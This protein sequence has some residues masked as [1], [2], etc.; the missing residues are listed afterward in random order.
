[1]TPAQLKKLDQQLT[2]FLD[3][4][5][6]DMGRPER[7]RA[8]ALYLTGLLLSGER[9][10]A[11][12]MGRRLASCD[13]EFEGMRQKLQQC[14]SISRWADEE[15]RRRL[16]LRFEKK[17]Q[18]EAFIIDDTGFPKK[19]KHSVG[20]KRQYSG[21]LGRRDSCQVAPSLHVASN[22]SSGCIGMRLYLPE[23]W[24]SDIPRRRSVGVPEDVVFQRKW[25]IAVDL[26]DDALS[27]G[28]PKRLVI[29]DAGF[30]EGTG[31]RDALVERGCPYLVGIPSTHTM[32]PPGSNPR[33]P[34]RQSPVGRPR[35]RY[36]DGKRKPIPISEVGEQLRFRKFTVPNGRGGTKSGHFAFERIQLA[37]R[38]AKGRPPSDKLWLICEWRPGKKE[39][40]YHVSNLPGSTTKS[41]LVRLVK[42]RWRVERD[43]Q[44]MKS[45]IGLDHYE[46]RTWR[47]F[48]HH[49]TLCAVAHGFLAIQRR[50]SPPEGIPV[51]A[52]HGATTAP[53]VAARTNRRVPTVSPTV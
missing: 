28:L 20:V 2:E 24:A 13:E 34:E 44:E 39:Y 10:T 4:I 1:M 43:Y 35:T 37:E 19:G 18:P 16:A 3:Y 29:A 17:L 30:G 14:V 5:T 12:S 31:F 21:T 47:G 42:L 38:H 53:A 52:A 50:L 45:E 6:D 32:W 33:K 36:M 7:R 9:K 27:W 40:R 46:G 22:D 15:L 51:D 25:E 49:V 8:M 26:L 41:E 11:V 23:D 48:H